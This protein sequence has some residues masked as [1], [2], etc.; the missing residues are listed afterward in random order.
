MKRV[1]LFGSSG[2]LGSHLK[3]K[4]FHLGYIVEAPSSTEC[5]LLDYDQLIRYNAYNNYRAYDYIINCAVIYTEDPYVNLVDEGILNFNFVK[6]CHAFHPYSKII[7]FGSDICYSNMYENETQYLNNNSEF[8][9]GKYN[10][11]IIVK[12]SLLRALLLSKQRFNYYVL[13]SMFGPNFKLG[14]FHLVPKL[15]EDISNKDILLFDTF[16]TEKRQV[17]F[18]ED[19]VSNIINSLNDDLGLINLGTQN[20]LTLKE[21][22]FKIQTLTKKQQPVLFGINSTYDSKQMSIK[23]ALSKFNKYSDTNL[24]YSLKKTIEYYEKNKITK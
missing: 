17:L 20:T 6:F 19:V 15:I 1:L 21:L 7:C 3:D 24:D 5:N 10:E 12:K 2:F 23:L 13:T 18:V 9:S 8:I 4:L 22:V 14:D 11:Y 16:G